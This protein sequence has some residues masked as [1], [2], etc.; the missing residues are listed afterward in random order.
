VDSCWSSWRICRAIASRFLI[1]SVTQQGF[2]WQSID[3]DLQKGYFMLRDS[4]GRDLRTPARLMCA[5]SLIQLVA[6][7]VKSMLP[8]LRVITALAVLAGGTHVY[9]VLVLP[10]PPPGPYRLAFVTSTTRDATSS[11][12]ADYNAFVTAAASTEPALVAL[13]TTWSAIASTGAVSAISN[14]MTDPSPA[15][16][17]GVPIF[18]VTGVKIA[19]HYDDLWDGS[20]DAPLSVTQSGAVSSSSVST[21]TLSSGNSSS[22][23]LGN[24]SIATTVGFSTSS[25][26]WW[27]NRGITEY[28]LNLRPIYAISGVLSGAAVPEP[29]AFLCVGLMGGLMGLGSLAWKQVKSRR[30]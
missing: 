29:S 14:T 8:V 24:N 20:L 28:Y 2:H 30:R 13:G 3:V 12:I 26:S 7:E 22:T 15:G 23:F 16:D 1:V 4:H 25:D 17:T 9:A 5:R 6:R 10:P 27:I 11:N 18:T 21:G 19:D